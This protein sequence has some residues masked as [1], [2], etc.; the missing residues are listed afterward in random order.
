MVFDPRLKSLPVL[1]AE[2]SIFRLRSGYHKPPPAS[3]A[4]NN[5]VSI[6]L[7]VNSPVVS[8]SL[9]YISLLTLCWL[10]HPPGASAQ[11]QDIKF[12]NFDRR[13]GLQDISHANITRDSSG[14]IWL[15]GSGITRYDGT[16]IKKYRKDPQAPNSL[17][18]DYTDNLVVDKKGVLWIGSAGGI[19]YYDPAIDGFHYLDKSA[20]EKIIYAYAFAY[21]GRETLWFSSNLG[22]CR[23]NTTTHAITT[24]SLTGYT[25]PVAALIDHRSRVWTS[26]GFEGLLVYD[27]KTNR[28]QTFK[29]FDKEG[30]SLYLPAL[31]MD[32]HHQVWLARRKG[33][34]RIDADAMTD[35]E[36]KLVF[37][38]TGDLN[39][40]SI[41]AIT[42]L[43][44]YT[45]TDLLW[46]GTENGLLCFDIVSKKITA[47]FLP[48]PTN[49]YSILGNGI[50]G[51]HRDKD[52]Q[53]W[54]TTTK[55]ISMINPGSQNFKTRVV[56]ELAGEASPYLCDLAADRENSNIVWMGT[57]RQGIIKYDWARKET[58][59]WIKDFEPGATTGSDARALADD[60]KGTIWIGS[61]NHLYR[62][63]KST[64]TIT[65]LPPLPTEKLFTYR[66]VIRKLLWAGDSLLIASS[67]GLVS[68]TPRT[69]SYRVLFSGKGNGDMNAFN[70]LYALLDADGTIWCSS[71]NGVA[72]IDPLTKEVAVFTGPPTTNGIPYLNGV[73]HLVSDGDRLLLSTGSGIFEFNKKTHALNPLPLPAG[74][75]GNAA[76]SMA[77][78]AAGNY[79][80]STERGLVFVNRQ[81]NTF[82]LFTSYDGLEENF[83]LMPLQWI[84]NQLVFKSPTSFTCIDPATVENNR[85]LPQP[86]ITDFRIL[87]SPRLFDPAMVQTKAYTLGHRENFISFDFNAFEFNYPDK[88][89]FAYRLSGF[90]EDWI[91][92]DKKKS[93]T[94]TN[95]P[96]GHYV[97]EMKAANS[98]GLWSEPT[99]FMLYIRPA[100]WQ[101]LAFKI[102]VALLLLAALYAVYRYRINQLLKLQRVRNRISADLHDDIGSTIS[103]VR[104]SNAMAMRSVNDPGKAEPI[105]AEM[106]E[107][108]KKIGESLDD[109]VWNINTPN[110]NWKDL[111]ARMRR[112]AAQTLE[113]SNIEY[114][115]NFDEPQQE[116]PLSL[117]GRRDL[118][119]IYKETVNNAAKH[120]GASL[121]II[122]IKFTASQI[123]LEISDNG[124]G[125][126]TASESA[127]NGLKNMKQRAANCR[128]DFR[129]S[130]GVQEGTQVYFSMKI[131]QKS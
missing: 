89:Q 111:L 28:S 44:A 56:K 19:C 62:L 32:A 45:G 110:T 60:G 112:Y 67:T 6:L 129:I 122:S 114:Q 109:I 78:D 38:E 22:L 86:V 73:S 21:D 39:N 107:D 5:N 36:G 50:N 55:G 106:N 9:R 87:E 1:P 7:F 51:L 54:A 125:F 59:Q 26:T 65:R 99:R 126:D 46:I 3:R 18:E 97:F 34:I 75:P 94:Y 66:T 31:F 72:R 24:T 71:V 58:L 102:L 76:M 49:P 98:E 82:R 15:S 27:P 117:E 105:L 124:R 14:Y 16:E 25:H 91:H 96:P 43:P 61:R 88:V 128:A 40:T 10:L 63:V 85:R 100:F 131:T 70:L 30:A 20:S 92:S 123:I 119:L 42:S 41:N 90:S 84:G 116:L 120:S 93:A 69:A 101:T 53:L 11:L 37:E 29:F 52:G 108:L 12:R 13:S 4:E 95:I 17:R 68:Y 118:F 79:W 83:S 127:R 113:N 80:I 57:N 103:A 2:A 23:L 81:K 121:V 74:A 77:L 104:I 64:G 33:L 130:S 115:L 8:R 48:V 35:S 47:Q